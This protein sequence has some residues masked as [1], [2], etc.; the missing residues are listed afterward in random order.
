MSSAEDG[1]GRAMRARRSWG[2]CEGVEEEDEAEQEQGN[3]EGEAPGQSSPSPSARQQHR[4]VSATG[5]RAFW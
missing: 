5:K 1:V 3:G 4:S 2:G